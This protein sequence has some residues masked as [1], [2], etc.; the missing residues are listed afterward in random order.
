[1]LREV[2]GLLRPH[3]RFVLHD[4]CPPQS[5]DWLYY[6]YFPKARL[7]DFEDFWPPETI[8]KYIKTAGF[9]VLNATY[10]HIEFDED[11]PAWLDIVR[12]RDTRSQLQAI[13]AAAYRQGVRRL[14]RDI[15]DPKLPRSRKN[16]LCLVTIRGDKPE[17]VR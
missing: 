14:K 8:C 4:M 2:L 11:L 9:A 3:G 13:S 17:P 15:A 1:M 10:Q 16:R 12:R 7:R 5:Q 6:E